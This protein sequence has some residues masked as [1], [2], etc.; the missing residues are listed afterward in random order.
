MGKIVIKRVQTATQARQA[1]TKTLEFVSLD[2][3][4]AGN[5]LVVLVCTT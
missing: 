1:V 5:L 3:M 4:M 2:V